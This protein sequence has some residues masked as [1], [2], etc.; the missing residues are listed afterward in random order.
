MV[1]WYD[2]KEERRLRTKQW[3]E[4]NPEQSRAAS[5]AWSD[6][7]PDKVKDYNKAY[8]KNH[9]EKFMNN[10]KRLF[11]SFVCKP[12]IIERDSYSCQ[13][14]GINKALELHHC[15]PVASDTNDSNILNPK[16]MITLCHECH[17]TAHD[18]DYHKFN[19]KLAM[20]LIK[21]IKAKEAIKPTILP[22]YI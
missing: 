1:Q 7:H 14:C 16:N 5:K 3:C 17:L 19:M 15:L 22:K 18:G 4:T 11:C 6:A 12:I 2:R 10:G 13:L 21:I 20:E 9:P 8:V